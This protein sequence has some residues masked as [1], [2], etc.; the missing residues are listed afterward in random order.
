MFRTR[1]LM[2]LVLACLALGWWL[3][4]PRGRYPAPS[5]PTPIAATRAGS[6][7]AHGCPLPPL[8]VANQPPLQSA[9]PGAMPAFARDDAELVPLAGFSL[10]AR[11]LGS[12]AYRMDRESRYAPLDLALGWNRMADDA[13][14][15]RLQVSQGGRWFRYRWQGQP[16]IPREEIA[17]SAANMHMIPA[18]EAVAAALAKIGKDDRVRIHGW[19]VEVRA[20]DGWRWRS[21]TTRDDEGQGACEIVYVCAISQE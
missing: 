4:Q 6:A 15:A 17:R 9:V 5:L 16:P 8:V 14:L 2:V 13:V 21:S 1:W 20:R 19:L 7:I 11:V 12:L 18:D 3:S 10:D